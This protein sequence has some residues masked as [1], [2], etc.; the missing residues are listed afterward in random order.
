M[1]VRPVYKHAYPAAKSK[2]DFLMPPAPAPTPPLARNSR[3]SLATALAS[4]L[5]AG[6]VALTAQPVRSE[7]S[8][9]PV[10]PAGLVNALARELADNFVLPD[11]GARYAAALQSRLAS[12]A[13]AG[14]N[15]PEA[16]ARTLT[17]DLQ[18]VAKDGHLRV[19][20]PQPAAS[21]QPGH[22]SRPRLTPILAS[23]W[24]ADKVAYIDFGVFPGD[25]DTLK[26]LDAFIA[27]HAGASTLIIDARHHHGGGLAEMDHLFAQMFAKETPLVVMDTR[28][29]VVARSGGVPADGPWL[30]PAPA[31]DSVVRRVH[32]VTPAA[33]PVWARTKV[34]LLTS[35]K[36]AS[37]AE[38]LALSLKR[39]GRATLVGEVT[40]GAGNF[41]GEVD[42]PGGFT[43]FVPVGRTY[44]PDTGKGWE[45]TGVAPDVAVPADAALAKALE[46]IGV[47]P[48]QRRP[49]A[50]VS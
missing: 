31:P 15:D 10:A 38:H 17:S 39:T 27:E 33:H 26:Q 22:G 1:A 32:V 2:E 21:A 36:T 5:F 29:A 47:R 50:G 11:V 34:I 49:I 46:M 6:A 45:G 41:G 24:I 8:A 19:F 42:L 30:R 28:A 37:A 23:G 13:Y 16:L 9:Q 7:A 44:D 20:P 25:P 40:Y 12:G 43:A 48:D 4:L 18:A 35:G 3:T 14:I